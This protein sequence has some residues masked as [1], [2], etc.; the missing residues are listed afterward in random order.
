MQRTQVIEILKGHWTNTMLE[1]SFMGSQLIF[2][3]WS[4]PIWALLSKFRQKRMHLFWSI[5][6][7]DFRLR[8]QAEHA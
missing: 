2:S 3:N 4:K 6:N 8:Y 5:C 1:Q 7:L